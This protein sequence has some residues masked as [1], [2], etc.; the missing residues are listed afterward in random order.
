[1]L[2]LDHEFKVKIKLPCELVFS[3]LQSTVKIEIDRQLFS[4]NRYQ[5]KCQTGGNPINEITLI[6]NNTVVYLI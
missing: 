6:Y 4:I 1:M 5:G 2:T 3:M